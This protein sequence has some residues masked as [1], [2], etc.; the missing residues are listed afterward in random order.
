MVSEWLVACLASALIAK[1][2][3][4]ASDHLKPFSFSLDTEKGG[5][6]FWHGEKK[7]LS[8]IFILTAKY[9]DLNLIILYKALKDGI[10]CL[11]YK[12]MEE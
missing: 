4:L 7:K 10:K 11:C 9:V 2:A 3:P 5:K 8:K 1:Y 12:K 6:G